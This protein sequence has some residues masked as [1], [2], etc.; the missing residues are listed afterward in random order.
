M[1][2]WNETCMLSHLPIQFGDDIKVIILIKRN[3]KPCSEN[4][5]FDDGYTPLTFPFDAT[6]NDYGG[7]ENVV[8]PEYALKQLQS[9]KLFT[10][11][12]ESYNFTSV[13]QLV[14]DINQDCIYLKSNIG[15]IM[16]DNTLFKLECI[17]IHKKLY[18]TLIDQ[19][20]IRKPYGITATFYELYKDRYDAV[21]NQ[22]LALIN[23]KIS[24]KEK[25]FITRI[26]I[27]STFENQYYGFIKPIIRKGFVTPDTI[28]DFIDTVCKYKLFTHALSEGRIGY[29]TRCGTGDQS[30]SIFTQKIIAE[31]I[32]NE[33]KRQ[34]KDGDP[35]YDN[36]E[37]IFWYYQAMQP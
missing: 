7:I 20:A 4:I 19:M 5:Y 11:K 16:T 6:Y 21:K 30:R 29:I 28:D 25:A 24:S 27:E 14:D 23:D 22:W 3:N 37:T 26:A 1:G 8:L 10:N 12:H 36:E 32:L 31:F 35:V 9:V 33:A 13:E 15:E 18:D 2:S 17:Y 34:T